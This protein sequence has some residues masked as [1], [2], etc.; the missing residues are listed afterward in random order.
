[1]SNGCA[2][3]ST[4]FCGSMPFF[5]SAANS[6]CSL[7]PSQTPTFLPRRSSTDVD[8]LVLERDLGHPGAGEDLGDVDDVLALVAGRE[9][10]VEPVDPELRLSAEHD[11]LGD[12]VRARPA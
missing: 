4:S 3:I 6:L 7:P 10:V 1:M 5:V 9:Q 11:L 12:D 8:P 2:T